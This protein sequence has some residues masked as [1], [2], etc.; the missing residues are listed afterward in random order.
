MRLGGGA[1][2]PRA[3]PPRA[4]RQTTDAPSPPLNRN[5]NAVCVAAPHLSSLRFSDHHAE[6]VLCDCFPKSGGTRKH[7]ET[8]VRQVGGRVL[9]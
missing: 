3:R 5:N 6:W 9:R 2:T 7:D 8:R 4:P 1:P